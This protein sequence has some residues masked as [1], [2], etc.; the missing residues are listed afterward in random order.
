[1]R[2][3][4]GESDCVLHACSSAEQY[5]DRGCPELL[6][7]QGGDSWEERAFRYV[8]DEVA[9]GRFSRDE[10]LEC[11][12]CGATNRVSRP[13]LNAWLPMTCAA[14]AAA[15]CA[16]ALQLPR[17]LQELLGF[18]NAETGVPVIFLIVPLQKASPWSILLDETVLS[19]EW[20][21][22]LRR[23]GFDPNAAIRWTRPQRPWWRLYHQLPL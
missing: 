20:V 1:M 14:C 10:D 6:S 22:L 21:R 2:L 15:G 4:V 23:G 13:P 3:Y 16:T 8:R 17:R 9:S 5:L 18:S 19:D 7:A 11:H 12:A